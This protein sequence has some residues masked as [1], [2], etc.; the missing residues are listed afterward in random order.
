GPWRKR[1]GESRAPPR[2]VRGDRVRRAATNPLG[3][4]V[5]SSDGE[6]RTREFST[7]SP[8][9]CSAL[10]GSSPGG[11]PPRQGRGLKRKLENAVL[12]LH[13]PVAAVRNCANSSLENSGAKGTGRNWV[14]GSARRRIFWFHRGRWPGK[15]KT[16]VTELVGGAVMATE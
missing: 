7:R 1:F 14:N 13:R 4:G 12:V 10:V 16:A 15:A 9:R 3:S 6:K 11:L 8:R 5:W 2:G